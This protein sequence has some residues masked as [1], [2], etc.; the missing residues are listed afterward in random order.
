MNTTKHTWRGMN[1]ERIAAGLPHS[2]GKS[3]ADIRATDPMLA[4]RWAKFITENRS[5]IAVEIC[6]KVHA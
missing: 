1:A 5:A 2:Q 4:N 3:A 6:A